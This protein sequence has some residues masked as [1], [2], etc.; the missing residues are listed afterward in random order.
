MNPFREILQNANA[1]YRLQRRYYWLTTVVGIGAIAVG[2]PL[3]FFVGKT[4]A[5]FTHGPIQAEAGNIIRG[6]LFI[7]SIP[8]LFY[9]CGVAVASLVSLILIRRRVLSPAEAKHYALLSR[10]PTRWFIP[11][12]ERLNHEQSHTN[13]AP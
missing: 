7:A 4:L 5:V 11:D 12:S 2:I 8:V 10:Y 1:T 3:A 6:L 9:L 13:P